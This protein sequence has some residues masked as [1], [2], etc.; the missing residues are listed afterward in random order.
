MNGEDQTLMKESW[1]DIFKDLP[2][3]KKIQ[4]RLILMSNGER[5]IGILSGSIWK[6]IIR[7]CYNKREYVASVGIA[8]NNINKTQKFHSLP[9]RYNNIRRSY[10]KALLLA[11]V[12]PSCIV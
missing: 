2:Y 8:D 11:N 9:K 12:K 1:L 10:R 7:F 6:Q 3:Y 5:C 4:N